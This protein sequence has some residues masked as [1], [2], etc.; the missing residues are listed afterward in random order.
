MPVSL[1]CCV[2]EKGFTIIPS[3]A[4]TAKYCSYRCHQ[5][6]AGRKG[7]KI[8]GEQMQ[9]LSQ[10]QAYRKTSGRH[11][12]RVIAESGL[13]RKLGPKEVVHHVD[14]DFLNNHPGNLE[15]LPSQ[16]EH[17]RRHIKQMLQARKEKYGY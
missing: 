10:G 17:V 16:A 1:I 7:G 6:G 2:C 5:V 3:R 14:G 11:S 12:H 15:V 9:A 4:K 13:G 8:R